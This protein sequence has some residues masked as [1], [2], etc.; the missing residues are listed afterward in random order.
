MKKRYSVKSLGL[1]LG[2]EPEDIIKVANIDLIFVD[3]LIM[4]GYLILK[5]RRVMFSSLD[6]S[7]YI[8]EIENQRFLCVV[9]MKNIF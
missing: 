2:N 3:E 8:N 7:K 5:C 1:Y 6:L 4:N 9:N